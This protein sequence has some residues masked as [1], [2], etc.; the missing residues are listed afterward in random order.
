MGQAYKIDRINLITYKGQKKKT[1]K[2]LRCRYMAKSQI[3]NCMAQ[4]QSFEY[5]N[6]RG[7][8]FKKVNFEN[9]VFSG[10]DFWGTVFNDCKF[11]NAK[12]QDCIFMASKFR[13]CD[14]S[15]ATF[16]Y[17]TIVNT[18]IDEC[19]NIDISS[20]VF[21]YQTYP[22]IDVYP[23][24]RQALEALKDN[25]NLKK[26]K[27]LYISDKKYN[28]LNL[29]LL[30]KRFNN[31]LPALLMEL[32]NHSTANITTYKKLERTLNKFLKTDII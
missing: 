6:F 4:S 28:S 13:N 3:V 2:S 11:Q 29:F 7:S 19:H 16:S 22:T 27:V 8:H 20:G 15:G 12:F 26:N 23:E 17:S 18:N 9:T 24:L 10:C 32:A 5:V 25:R 31:K 30:Q 1:V 14:F 21:R